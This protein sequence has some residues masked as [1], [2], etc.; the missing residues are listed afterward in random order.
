MEKVLVFD[1]WGDYAHFR[2]F[3]TTTSPL[4]F[5]IAPR[6]SIAGL[7]GAIV[8][9]GKDDY[10][11]HFS[12]KAARIGLRILSPVKKTRLGINLINTKDNYWT[13]IR[14]KGHEPRTQI[15]TE[16]LKDPKFRIY[17]LHLD[18]SIHND[19]RQ[20]LKEHKSVYTP[21]LGLSELIC[22]FSF[23]GEFSIAEQE[24]F[25]VEIDSVIPLSG[26]VEKRESIA[27]ETGKKYFKE[28][29]PVEM[30]PER[31][32]TEYGEAVYE[33][34]GKPLR[35]TAKRFWELENGERIIF[36]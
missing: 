3:Y 14:K 2:K 8:G 6:T 1:I 25:Q 24:K 5:S 28:K 20:N 36:F 32:V 21:C 10:L 29:L 30:T 12:K 17:V 35:V 23:V 13:L 18:E 26:L 27:F 15:R 34:D 7:L 9:L 16:F 22:N 4:T 19:L 33:A 11:N 31:V